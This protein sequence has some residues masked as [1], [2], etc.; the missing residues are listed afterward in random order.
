MSK[1]KKELGQFFTTNVDYILSGFEHLVKNKNVIDPF[2]GGGDLLRWAE[3]NAAASVK[4]FDIDQSLVDNKNIF[5]NDSLTIIPK[6][7]FNLTN[8]PYLGKNKMTKEQ[9]E[10]YMVDAYEDF[11]L[12]S[13]KRIINSECPEGII[14]IPVNFFSAENSDQLRVEFLSLYEITGVNYFKEQVFDDTTYNVVAFHYRKKTTTSKVQKVNFSFYPDNVSQVFE[15]KA[16]FNYRIAGEE[17]SKIEKIKPLKAIRLTEKY[18]NNNSGNAK[19]SAFF[20]DKNTE[21]D[22]FVNSKTRKLIKNNI[23]LLNC[24]DSNGSENGWIKAEDVRILGKDC[25]V[26]KDSSRNIAYVMFDSLTTEQQE[27]IIV[28]FNQILNDLRH[29]YKSLFLT[30]FRDNDRKRISFDFCYKLISYCAGQ[31]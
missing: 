16:K 26:G 6:S 8:P 10:K 28:L 22:Y 13:I 11:Y 21:F 23:I 1:S 20:N 19:V 5:W 24:I 27:K 18:L 4:G 25:L 31:I 15:L 17:L 30:N 14:I 2:A 7:D 29:K 9:K 12:L 3:K